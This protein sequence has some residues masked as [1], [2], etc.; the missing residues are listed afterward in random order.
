M[1]M[2]GFLSTDVGSFRNAS[3]AVTKHKMAGDKNII[4]RVIILSEP[5][6]SR[7]SLRRGLETLPRLID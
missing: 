5:L 6:L 7:A 3:T 2:R 4:T 1:D